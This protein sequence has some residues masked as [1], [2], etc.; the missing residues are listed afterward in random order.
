MVTKRGTFENRRQYKAGIP[1]ILSQLDVPDGFHQTGRYCNRLVLTRCNNSPISHGATFA[2]VRTT[3][4]TTLEP[5]ETS[6]FSAQALGAQSAEILEKFHKV[7]PEVFNASLRSQVIKYNL[8]HKIKTTCQPV[9]SPARRL[10]PEKLRFAKEELIKLID[11][12]I[13]EPS[14]SA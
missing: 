9:P 12:G 11:Q 14:N 1:G 2:F 5:L 3:S 7:Y 4:Q 10:S 6:T 13:M 8:Q